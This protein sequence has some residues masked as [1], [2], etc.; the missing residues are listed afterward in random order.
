MRKAY[1]E[2]ISVIYNYDFGPNTFIIEAI[3]HMKEASGDGAN[4]SIRLNGKRLKEFIH[5]HASLD[6]ENIIKDVLDDEIYEL[7]GLDW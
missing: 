7:I 5:E 2:G 6:E 3:S 4:F 1:I